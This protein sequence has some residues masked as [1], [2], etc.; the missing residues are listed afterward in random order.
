MIFNESQIPAKLRSIAIGLTHL[1][2]WK[3]KINDLLEK[4]LIRKNNSTWS[5]HIFHAKNA[6]QLERDGPK[7]VITFKPLSKILRWIKY[8]IPNKRK[9]T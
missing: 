1:E 9:L 3:N 5:C 6:T 2:I 7:L 4:Q 8:L